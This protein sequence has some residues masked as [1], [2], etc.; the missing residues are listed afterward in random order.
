MSSKLL[1]KVKGEKINKGSSMN[2]D[3]LREG[4]EFYDDCSRV[5][6]PYSGCPGMVRGPVEIPSWIRYFIGHDHF[7]RTIATSQM[8]GYSDARSIKHVS[9]PT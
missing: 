7:L 3:R 2:D 4:L 5:P 8:K 1:K 9:S 6:Y